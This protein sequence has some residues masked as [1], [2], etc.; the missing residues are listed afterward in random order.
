MKGNPRQSLPLDSGLQLF[1]P[2]FVNG[3]WIPD[4]NGQW[5][6]GFLELNYYGFQ[7]PGSRI[8]LYGEI[9]SLLF[10][11]VLYC[12]FY[13]FLQLLLRQDIFQRG[14]HLSTNR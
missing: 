9:S 6:S 11:I 4:S 13:V 7:S 2:V 10:I 5:D 1:F 8:P 3:T 14:H 12:V